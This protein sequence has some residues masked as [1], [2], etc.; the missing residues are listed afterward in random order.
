MVI[1]DNYR[2]SWSMWHPKRKGK[3]HRLCACFYSGGGGMCVH[4]H[5]QVHTPIHTPAEVR[6][7]H[8]VPCSITLRLTSLRCVSLLTQFLLLCLDWNSGKP[9]APPDHTPSTTTQKLQAYLAAMTGCFTWKLGS[10]C[11]CNH[12]ITEPSPQPRWEDVVYVSS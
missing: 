6:G 10:S 12:L 8:W 5:F 3:G 1:F 2:P 7:R 9:R 11:L 4:I